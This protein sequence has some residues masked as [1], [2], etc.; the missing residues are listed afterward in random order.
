MGSATPEV[1]AASACSPGNQAVPSVCGK[2]AEG[3]DLIY[4]DYSKLV[5][6]ICFRILRNPTE[7]EDAVQDVFV[8][9]LRN[10]HT[11]RGESSFATWLYR[12]AT[13]TVLMR[14]RSTRRDRMASAQ[15]Q[16]CEGASRR[17]PRTQDFSLSAFACRIDLKAAVNSLPVG[18]RAV[19][20][21]HDIQGYHHKEISR[22]LGRSIGDSKSQLHRARKRL[23]VFLGDAVAETTAR[24]RPAGTSDD[25]TVNK[26][27]TSARHRAV[28][29]DTAVV[30]RDW[31]TDR[32]AAPDPERE[33]NNGTPLDSQASDLQMY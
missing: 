16:E 33:R 23:R 12:V 17:I 2:N 10:V 25:V 21:L 20:I 29:K 5:R 4:R 11:F 31:A 8:Q 14:V 13:N 27:D 28:K 30:P 24:C 3:F 6:A 1:N 15:P 22:I 7:A 26:L 18:Y 9:I 32:N 19:F